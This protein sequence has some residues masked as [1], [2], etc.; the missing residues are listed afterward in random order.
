MFSPPAWSRDGDGLHRAHPAR[1]GARHPR[2]PQQ[3][4][5]VFVDLAALAARKPAEREKY[6][7]EEADRGQFPARVKQALTTAQGAAAMADALRPIVDERGSPGGHTAPPGTP[8]LQPTDERRRT[9][10]HYTPRSLTEPI[11]RHALE[12]AFE[13]IG[14]DATPEQ[15]LALKVCDPAMGS[16]AFLVEACRQLATRLVRA[17]TRHR[18]TRPEIPPDEDEDLLARRLV[19]QRCLY[20]VDRNPM[21]TDLARLSLWLATLAR[22]HEFTFLDHALKTGDS[23]VGL[24]ARQIGA[25]TW[26]DDRQGSLFGRFVAERVEKAVQGRAAI[27]AAPD[28][29]ERAMQEAKHAVIETTMA[30]VRVLGDAVL[31]CFFGQIKPKAR[32]AALYTLQD[33]GGRDSEAMWIEVR[34]RAATLA[35]GPHPVRPFHW[36]IEFPEVFV[37]A[38]VGFDAIFG[39]PPFLGGLRVSNMLGMEMFSFF[40]TMF[41]ETGHVADL[42]AYLFRMSFSLL[43][44][45]GA[46][47]LLATN[48]ISQGDTRESGLTY[49]RKHGGTIYRAVRRMEWPGDAAVVVSVIHVGKG[50]SASSPRPTLDGK[51]VEQITAFLFPSGGDDSPRRLSKMSALFSQGTNIWS[52]GFL[53]GETG[54][55]N[56]ISEAE[57]LA[58]QL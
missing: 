3:P 14:D 5:E 36:E 2:R 38:K 4:H 16:G 13:R 47:G 25:L 8:L 32:Q 11:V 53:F 58:L 30:D 6:L 29:V 55:P 54:E 52:P 20:G 17:W 27:R 49:I 57:A 34:K 44:V 31:G 15:V 9:G 41:P 23:L 42:V 7:K 45:G 22:D 24:T 48:S 46:L 28:D 43:R 18:G 10:S 26:G 39:N 19:A 37:Q 51:P 40:T 21:A 33:L 50:M 1:S 12:P 56:S 35:H